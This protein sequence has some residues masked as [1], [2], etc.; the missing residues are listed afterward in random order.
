VAIYFLSSI[1]K[2]R[3]GGWDWPTGS[4]FAWAMTRRGTG[5]GR[6]LIDPPWILIAGQFAI[7]ALEMLTPLLL[8]LRGRYRYAFVV[9]LCGF[10]LCT[11]LTLKIH[12]LPL[13]VCLLAFLPLER[14]QERFLA[15]RAD[16]Q[17]A[18]TTPEPAT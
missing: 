11:F 15:R 1:A 4:T 10:H 13:V 8:V 14:I 6:L 3:F 7:M 17:Q 12:F 2:I 5:L 16:R 9:L 18:P